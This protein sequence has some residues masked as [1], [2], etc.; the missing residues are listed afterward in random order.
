MVVKW[1][2]EQKVIEIGVFNSQLLV[3]LGQLEVGASITAWFGIGY[4]IETPA[5]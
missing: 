3:I 2:W 4:G 5:G 1:N